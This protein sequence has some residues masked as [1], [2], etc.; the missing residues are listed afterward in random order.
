MAHRRSRCL[1]VRTIG[2]Q[3][4][5]AQ[6][7]LFG[8]ETLGAR[9]PIPQ[10]SYHI[11]SSP[12]MMRAPHVHERRGTD[13]VHETSSGVPPP[14]VEYEHLN[15]HDKGADLFV[16]G[17]CGGAQLD[18]VACTSEYREFQREALE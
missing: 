16:T 18:F 15:V 9:V 14:G 12:L 7:S 11:E 6:E 13:G 17:C 10:P 2:E 8:P 4:T 5:Q 3:P 1:H